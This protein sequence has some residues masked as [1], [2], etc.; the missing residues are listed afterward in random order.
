V[1]VGTP[2]RRIGAVMRSSIGAKIFGLAV[3]L[4]AL[5]IVL[6]AFLLWHVTRLNGELH[7]IAN[8]DMP[9]DTAL[10][11]LSDAGF[12]RRLAFEHWVGALRRSPPDEAAVAEAERAYEKESAL[13]GQL[14]ETASGLLSDYPRMAIDLAA[15]TEV[16]VLVKQL[17]E[18]YPETFRKER[19]L[20]ELLRSAQTERASN[21]LFLLEDA[22]RRRQGRRAELERVVDD[23][24]LKKSQ[25]LTEEQ[26][27]VFGLTIAVTA[28]L[29]ALG[30]VVAK[31]LTQRLVQ[32]VRDLIRGIKTLE[33]GDLTVVLPVRTSDEIGTLTAAFNTFAGEMRGKEE[34]R[35]TFGKY[36]DP[37]ILDQFILK[38]GATEAMGG[39]QEMTIG[40]TDLVG[41]SALSEDLTPAGMVN[42]LNRHFSLQAEAIQQQRGIVD[43]FIGD[44]VMAFW[45]APFTGETE[46]AEL[47]CRAALRQIEALA[48]F[49]KML[50]ELTGLRRNLPN[51]DARVGLNTGEVVVGNIGSENTRSYTV[52]GD[53]VNLASR[54]EGANRYYGTRILISETTRER[55]GGRIVTREIDALTVKGKTEPTRVFELLGI[56]GE[57]G[58]AP[59][60]LRD[61]FETSLAA[62]RAQDWTTAETGFHQCL[63][64]ASNDGPA[65]LFLDRVMVLRATPPPS[66][67][68]GVWHLESK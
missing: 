45:G 38:P 28:A 40:F 36:I 24:V 42:L 43:K 64:L 32:P 59:L 17:K 22:H 12:R 35:R 54:L 18:E 6:A 50:P 63:A 8:R 11:Q 62:Y 9:L 27:E 60:R 31:I 30:L 68:N 21:L 19:E 55:A 14:L 25:L 23:L 49:R 56:A 10:S 20:V 46:H 29:V 51:I 2:L 65:K 13:V 66:D 67:W 34:Q 52:I 26:H 61:A 39:R 41:F 48:A 5:N 58:D 57:T 7:T 44:A 4:V 53:A 37:R 1:V 3:F 33:T 47:A 16:E 15:L